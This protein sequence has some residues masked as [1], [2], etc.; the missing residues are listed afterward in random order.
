VLGRA[1]IGKSTFCQHVAY[2]L[3]TGSIWSEHKLV[4]LV[5]LRS[6]TE[7]YYPTGITQVE[8]ARSQTIVYGEK[9]RYTEV[10]Q[11]YGEIK[12]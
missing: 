10:V 5:R 4:V 3:A 7:K 9:Q 2:Q 11:K 6:L 1:G 12:M 8:H